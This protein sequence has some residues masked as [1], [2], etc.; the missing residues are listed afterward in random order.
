V[1]D[2]EPDVETSEAELSEDEEQLVVSEW[3][4]PNKPT[5]IASLE[6]READDDEDVSANG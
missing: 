4:D 1:E 3:P 6:T 5:A 2:S